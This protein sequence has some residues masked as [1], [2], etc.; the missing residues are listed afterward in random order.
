MRVGKDSP[1]IQCRKVLRG[2]GYIMRRMSRV[3][4]HPRAPEVLTYHNNTR[5]ASHLALC[6]RC[7]QMHSLAVSSIKICSWQLEM[8][9]HAC[10]IFVNCNG[11]GL[12]QYSLSQARLNAQV[13]GRARE[14]KDQERKEV[15]QDN[16]GLRH[17]PVKEPLG[18]EF[19]TISQEVSIFEAIAWQ[20]FS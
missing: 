3:A 5:H 16:D 9:G 4:A 20:T 12:I 7:Q 11:E 2:T 10:H 19:C 6:T 15:S 18:Y 14:G 13:R 1:I 17:A 8:L